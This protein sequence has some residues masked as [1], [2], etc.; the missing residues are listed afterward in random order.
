MAFLSAW[1]FDRL[2]Q[3]QDFNADVRSRSTLEP[4]DVLTLDV[5][6]PSSSA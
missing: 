3:R 5:S 2:H 6:E 4:V 1:Q